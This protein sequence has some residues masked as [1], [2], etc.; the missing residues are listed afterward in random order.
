MPP[1]ALRRVP[2]GVPGHRHQGNGLPGSHLHPGR[3]APLPLLR[4]H[5]GQSFLAQLT[6]RTTHAHFHF[7]HPEIV[8][9]LHRY[10]LTRLARKAVQVD[11]FHDGGTHGIANGY[12]PRVL[13]PPTSG[14]VSSLEQEDPPAPW[15]RIA[16]RK[17]TDP[18]WLSVSRF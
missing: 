2:G 8:R 16:G 15:P 9:R 18:N 5:L 6:H 17:G 13:V 14:F 3:I 11:A 10:D 12:I 4:T 7:H 1:L